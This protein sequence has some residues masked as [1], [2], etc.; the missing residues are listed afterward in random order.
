MFFNSSPFIQ[1]CYRTIEEHR[2]DFC[3]GCG[4][5]QRD[6]FD[7]YEELDCGG[8]AP[9]HKEVN[10]LALAIIFIAAALLEAGEHH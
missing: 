4:T 6:E 1:P 7:F 9:A 2:N 3:N 8:A 10:A 5:G